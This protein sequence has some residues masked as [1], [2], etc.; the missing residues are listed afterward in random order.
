ML[1]QI[2]STE[3]SLVRAVRTPPPP[4]SI[5]N[6]FAP[7]KRSLPTSTLS[8]KNLGS[9]LDWTVVSAA[10]FRRVVFNTQGRFILFRSICVS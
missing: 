3:E 4:R 2:I 10:V 1:R 9:V 7:N 5:R 6:A 8:P